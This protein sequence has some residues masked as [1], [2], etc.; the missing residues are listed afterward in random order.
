MGERCRPSA[1][2]S[3]RHQSDSPGSQQGASSAFAVL[4]SAL[5]SLCD[6][7]AAFGVWNKR[8]K[9][10]AANPVRYQSDKVRL[11]V[12][13]IRARL[14]ALNKNPSNL[15]LRTL[16]AVSLTICV[17]WDSQ[18]KRTRGNPVRC[19][20]GQRFWR[21]FLAKAPPCEGLRGVLSSAL[22]WLVSLACWTW[23]NCKEGLRASSV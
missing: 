22:R 17:A 14:L 19:S 9:P 18:R 12:S 15:L 23:A 16:R 3:V 5:A 4:A 6:L 21:C 8:C 10:S 2:Y 11:R 1:K 13:T 20:G 7:G